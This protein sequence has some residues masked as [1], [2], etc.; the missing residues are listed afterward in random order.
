MTTTRRPGAPHE[1]AEQNAIR[2]IVARMLEQFPELSATEIERSVFGSYDTFDDSAVR[3]FIPVLV[4]RAT[5]RHLAEH[6][7]RRHRA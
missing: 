7:Y 4:E 1:A 6:S 5:R 2:R 3:D